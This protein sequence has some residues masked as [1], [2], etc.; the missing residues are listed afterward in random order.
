[1]SASIFLVAWLRVGATVVFFEAE[2]CA[3]KTE[4]GRDKSK[5]EMGSTV[6][7]EL[8]VWKDGNETTVGME[9]GG[10]VAPMMKKEL[11]NGDVLL[12]KVEGEL[13]ADDDAEDRV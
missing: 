8:L 10:Y 7:D 12:Y 1:M 2:V 3:S 9:T 11:V 5:T 6:M 4:E 13:A